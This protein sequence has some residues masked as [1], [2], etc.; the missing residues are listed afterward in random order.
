M[1]PVAGAGG[2]E[3][4]D[5]LKAALRRLASGVSIVALD[6]ED[7]PMGMAATSI[8]SLTMDP[9]AVLVCINQAASIHSRLS[10]GRT[11]SISILSSH[12][13]DVAAAFG[14]AVAR[15]QR[16]EVGDWSVGGAEPPLLE[17]AQACLV[18]AIDEIGRYGT[19]SI[20]IVKVRSVRLG[21]GGSPLIYQNG[22]YL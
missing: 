20:V 13:R 7:G 22:A 3:L 2:V 16:F 6:G 10:R 11:V 4:A 17:Q 19:H 8:T 12:Q 15:E 14:G 18:G 1:D 21:Q 5:S 9:P